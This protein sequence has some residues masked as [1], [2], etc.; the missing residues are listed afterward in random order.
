MADRADR[1]FTDR[2]TERLRSPD[3]LDSYLRVTNSSVWVVLATCI[4][5][6]AGLVA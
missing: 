6:V 2:A 3:D 4:C 5:L 1:V